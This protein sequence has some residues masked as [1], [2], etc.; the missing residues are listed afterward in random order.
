MNDGEE[1]EY[2]KEQGKSPL[3][4]SLGNRSNNTKTITVYF[5]FFGSFSFSCAKYAKDFS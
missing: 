5:A 1:K 4:L 3:L 2:G